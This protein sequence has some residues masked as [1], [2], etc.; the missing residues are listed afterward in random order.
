M[1]FLLFLLVICLLVA[2][3]VTWYNNRQRNHTY[4]YENPDRRVYT[5]QGYGDP[6]QPYT[7]QQGYGNRP[8]G[9]SYGQIYSNEYYRPSGYNDPE[10][11]QQQ[12]Y[13]QQGYGPQQEYPQQGYLQQGYGP[14]R[15]R[16]NP[17]MAGGLGALGGGLMGYG[18]G[19][20]VD[21]QQT[22]A[23]NMS[24]DEAY[25]NMESDA[26]GGLGDDFGGSTGDFGGGE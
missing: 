4:Q 6:E 5:R 17:W 24:S 26:G 10:D 7:Q 22:N 14:Q 25:A 2:L 8:D 16:M 11:N 21:E 19:Q 20:A 1:E 15:G 3:G 9:K 18:L 12:G 13:S 23:E